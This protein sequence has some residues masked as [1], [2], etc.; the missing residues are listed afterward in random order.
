MQRKRAFDWTDAH[1][2]QIEW[3]RPHEL[4]ENPQLFID[5]IAPDDFYMGHVST[6]WF[7]CGFLDKSARTC[8]RYVSGKRGTDIAPTRRA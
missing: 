7:L 1:V 5:G 2:A 8:H 6:F 3:K 4:A